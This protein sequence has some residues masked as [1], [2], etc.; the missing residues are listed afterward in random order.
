MFNLFYCSLRSQNE[1]KFAFCWVQFVL[2]LRP[3]CAHCA[4][5]LRSLCAHNLVKYLCALPKTQLFFVKS[6]NW[7]QI[8]VLLRSVAFCCARFALLKYALIMYPFA[9]ICTSIWYR[10]P[11][12]LIHFI[13]N[14]SENESCDLWY[15]ITLSVPKK[16]PSA[17]KRSELHN[18]ALIC[19]K[20]A[21]WP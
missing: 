1:R 17:P 14:K 21:L 11:T 12:T 20:C 6:A 4:L 9:N 19:S 8:C 7:A 18:Y 16:P 3:L 15:Q 2:T 13:E 10:T 5:T